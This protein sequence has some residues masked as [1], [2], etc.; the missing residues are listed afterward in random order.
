MAQPRDEVIAALREVQDLVA[1]STPPDAVLTEVNALLL[2]AAA[3][4]RPWPAE[5]GLLPAGDWS[6]QQERANALLPQFVLDEASDDAIK[7]RVT[8]SRFHHGGGGAVHGGIIPLV[9]DH[10]MG[11][12]TN[13]G[14]RARSRT[15]YLHVN[16]RMITPIGVELQ[17]DATIDHQEGRKI[18]A[19]GRLRHGADLLADAEGLFIVLRPGQP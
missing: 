12:L 4:L 19:S 13:V 6:G 5:D 8:F 16:Y 17:M 18:F 11:R 7:G 2:Q 15:A 10:L 14:G 9:F 3:E 1:G